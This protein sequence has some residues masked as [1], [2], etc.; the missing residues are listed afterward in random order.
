MTC[1]WQSAAPAGNGC[2]AGMIVGART[3]PDLTRDCG[4]RLQLVVLAL[5]GQILGLVH[6]VELALVA[7]G[8][9]EP[10][11][12]GLLEARRRRTAERA[13]EGLDG[14]VVAHGVALDH[15]AHA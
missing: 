2:I 10:V 6:L 4:P 14:E 5:Q 15:A 13:E 11:A 9:C 3:A 1:M 7:L 12:R 8:A